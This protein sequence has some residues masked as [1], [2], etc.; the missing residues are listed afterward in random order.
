MHVQEVAQSPKTIFR[1]AKI[2][3]RKF[4][5]GADAH[6]TVADKSKPVQIGCFTVDFGAIGPIA[7]RFPT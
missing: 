2:E 4:A 6:E 1:E 3:A 5:R 7:K